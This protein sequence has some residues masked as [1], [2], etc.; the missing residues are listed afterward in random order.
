MKN[1]ILALAIITLAFYTSYGQKQIKI[2]YLKDGNVADV[3]DLSFNFSY[4]KRNYSIQV[5]NDAIIIPFKLDEKQ[6]ETIKLVL[7]S[8][9]VLFYENK[10]LDKTDILYNSESNC[11]GKS[12]LWLINEDIFPFESGTEKTNV[13]LRGKCFYKV[14]IQLSGC[15]I[16][17]IHNIDTKC[18]NNTNRISFKNYVSNIAAIIYSNEYFRYPAQIYN[19]NVFLAN[20]DLNYKHQLIYNDSRSEQIVEVDRNVIPIKTMALPGGKRN[21]FNQFQKKCFVKLR[22]YNGISDTV[23]VFNSDYVVNSVLASSSKKY[24]IAYKDSKNEIIFDIPLFKDFIVSRGLMI[25]GKNAE[26]IESDSLSAKFIPDI[27]D[28]TL[29]TITLSCGGNYIHSQLFR[30]VDIPLPLLNLEDPTVETKKLKIEL[31]APSE[32]KIACPNDVKFLPEK[33]EITVLRGKHIIKQ[34]DIKNSELPT[35]NIGDII[36]VNLETIKH[37]KYD[38]S[39]SSIP[40]SLSRVLKVKK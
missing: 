29:A 22:V 28:D 3:K 7:N 36:V 21:E 23:L 32:Y 2:K 19:A 35:L 5:K 12:D 30:I 1:K 24:M 10:H 4:N 27:S 8:D 25:K 37:I 40:V 34:M 20:L 14:T 13:D 11:I 31:K 17:Y 39:V 15:G 26:I 33:G 9:T 18:P 16:R 6:L 38:G